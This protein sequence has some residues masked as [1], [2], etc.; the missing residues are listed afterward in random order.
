MLYLRMNDRWAGSEQVSDLTEPWLQTLQTVLQAR[1]HLGEGWSLSARLPVGWLEFDS[2]VG[3]GAQRISGFGDLSLGGT[4]DFA[5]L[6]GLA[7]HLPRITFGG[8]LV[9]PTGTQQ[10]LGVLSST[11]MPTVV[12]LGTGSFGLAAQLSATWLL[13]QRFGLRVPVRVQAPL[14]Y[15]TNNVRRGM[16]L[17][18]ALQALLLPAS[19]WVVSLG[20]SGRWRQQ[21]EHDGAGAVLNSGGHL[22]AVQVVLA[23]PL[24]DA[25]S[26]QA[27]GRVPVWRK[28]GGVQLSEGFSATLAVS[29]R[30]GATQTD[31]A[32]ADPATADPA[33]PRADKPPAGTPE[34]DAELPATAAPAG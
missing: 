12:S 26:L 3:Q 4:Y 10:S 28:L 22:A 1:H 15:A 34:P 11:S 5:G 2:D 7:G 27:S 17:T 33:K 31:P 30:L 23:A 24:S 9:L 20:V 32:T 16:G 25:W 8:E 29:W 13:S 18:Y 14:T 19:G 21:A 6:W